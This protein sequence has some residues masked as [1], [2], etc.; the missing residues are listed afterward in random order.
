MI[1][2]P[3]L[4][5]SSGAVDGEARA[6]LA[7]RSYSVLGFDFVGYGIGNLSKHPPSPPHS[8]HCANLSK[9]LATVGTLKHGEDGV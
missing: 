6:R 1:H 2:F 9:R 4:D 7:G 3:F 5:T 8:E